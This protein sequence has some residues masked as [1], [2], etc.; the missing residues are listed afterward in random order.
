MPEPKA[1]WGRDALGLRPQDFGGVLPS[2]VVG[3]PPFGRAGR[4]QQAANHFLSKALELLAPGGFLGMVMPGGFLKMRRQ[5]GRAMRGHLLD[6]CE[7][8]EVWEQPLQTVG[9]TAR[10]ETCVVIAR[11][12]APGQRHRH[13]VLFKS[14]YSSRKSAIRALREELR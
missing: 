5:K 9:L 7:L 8:L 1:L 11:K 2:V 10:Q 3:N 14:T 4:G 12:Y 13:P 6:T